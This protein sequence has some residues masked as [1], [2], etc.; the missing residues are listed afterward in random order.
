VC[1]PCGGLVGIFLNRGL[2]WQHYLGDGITS[3]AQEIYDPGHPAQITWILPD[4][5]PEGL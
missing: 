3:G 2:H 4:E 5:S 1:R